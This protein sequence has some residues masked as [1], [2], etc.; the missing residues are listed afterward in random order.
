RARP[1]S[2]PVAL[3][4]ESH[5]SSA[6]LPRRPASFTVPLCRRDRAATVD[7]RRHHHLIRFSEGFGL[8][9]ITSTQSAFLCANTKRSAPL[10][11]RRLTSLTSMGLAVSSSTV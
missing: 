3:L 9:A 7:A 2:G 6:Q 1:C 8:L 10:T 4:Y 11:M 5:P